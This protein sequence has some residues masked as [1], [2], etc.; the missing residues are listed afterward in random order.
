M[1]G[2]VPSRHVEQFTEAEMRATGMRSGLLA[3]LVQL[4]RKNRQRVPIPHGLGRSP[5]P[6]QPM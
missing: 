1:Q 3:K 5:A 6:R 2:A 4:R